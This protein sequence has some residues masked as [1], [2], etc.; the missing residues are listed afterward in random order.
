MFI[1]FKEVKFHYTKYE[2]SLDI[3]DLAFSSSGITAIVGHTGSGKS[4]LVQHLNAL[5]VCQSGQVTVNE[6]IIK[7]KKRID[8]YKLRKTVGLVFQFAENQL[9]KETV[10]TDI[11]FGPKNF[12]IPI[13]QHEEIVVNSLKA[14]GLD[15]SYR[16]MSPFE[17]SGGEKRRA[18][19]AGILAYSPSIIVFDEPTVGLDPSGIDLII[20]LIKQLHNTGHKIIVVTHDMDFLLQISDE[21]L[22]L[23]KGLVSFLGDTLQL[24]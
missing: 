10:E 6:F 4:T 17:M 16:T 12:K 20:D 7:K 5:L 1:E 21:V 15:L 13:E 24:F 11:L 22:V 9:F 23:N 8:L 18:A 19:I 3:K 2:E 14:V